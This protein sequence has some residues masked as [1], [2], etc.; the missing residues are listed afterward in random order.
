M[1]AA[2]LG[3]LSDIKLS[4]E[5][6]RVKGGDDALVPW[7]AV[8]EHVLP[9]VSVLLCLPLGDLGRR[10]G[11]KGALASHSQVVQPLLEP[12]ACSLGNISSHWLEPGLSHK[13][14]RLT[15]L[16]PRADSNSKGQEASLGPQMANR[17]QCSLPRSTGRAA[18]PN[19][20]P[21]TV[22]LQLG[23]PPLKRA[24]ENFLWESLVVWPSLMTI[25]V[26]M[27]V[28]GCL[29]LSEALR[30]S[31]PWWGKF[32]APPWFLLPPGPCAPSSPCGL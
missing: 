6:S 11:L 20:H 19:V 31:A 8:R 13:H 7:P 9:E 23:M 10:P 28:H 5:G 3:A 24:W 17:H 30:P 29:R 16:P 14:N 15:Q 12:P 32:I 4:C 1:G 27:C 25:S 18:A 2:K 22:P 26:C 21:H